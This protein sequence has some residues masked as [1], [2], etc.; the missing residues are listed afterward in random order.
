[1]MMVIDFDLFMWLW[2]LLLDDD[3]DGVFVVGLMDYV[4]YFGDVQWVFGYL[5]LFVCLLQVQQQFM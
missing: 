1:M 3:V 4:L 2:M 5:D